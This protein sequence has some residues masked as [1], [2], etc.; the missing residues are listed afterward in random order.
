MCLLVRNDPYPRSD[1]TV[2]I[3]PKPGG[4]RP[5]QKLG[6]KSGGVAYELPISEVPINQ[7][8]HFTVEIKYSSYD[9]ESN[10]AL[11][12]GHV[13]V[14]MNGKQVADWKGDVG[15]NDEKGPYFKYG[16]NK[17]GTDGFKVDCAGFTQTVQP[18]EQLNLLE[19]SLRS[20]LQGSSVPFR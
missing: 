3:K 15:K 17:P 10:K 6:N 18:S 19:H 12:S 9:I 2:R 20:L 1:N 4:I 13:K 11:T 8:I 14:W 5:Y 7:W 16:I